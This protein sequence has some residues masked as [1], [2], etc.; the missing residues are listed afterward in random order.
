MIKSK[1]ADFKKKKS[2]RTRTRTRRKSTTFITRKN[3]K[4]IGGHLNDLCPRNDNTNNEVAI[5][6]GVV[7]Q[8]NVFVSDVMTETIDYEY[9]ITWHALKHLDTFETFPLIY[10]NS[11]NTPDNKI[12]AVRELFGFANSLVTNVLFAPETLIEQP[13]TNDTSFRIH[14]SMD[15]FKYAI[16]CQWTDYRFKPP[17]DM[18]TEQLINT[19]FNN[20]YAAEFNNF[21]PPKLKTYHVLKVISIYR[22]KTDP[23]TGF[24]APR[25]NFENNPIFSNKDKSIVWDPHA[26]NTMGLLFKEP[27][28]TQ[29]IPKTRKIIEIKKEP[30]NMDLTGDLINFNAIKI[31]SSR[32][33]TPTLPTKAEQVVLNEQN[34]TAKKEAVKLAE[35]N[36]IESLKETKRKDEETRITKEAEAVAAKKLAEETEAVAAKKLA[37]ETEAA[38]KLAEEAEAAKKTTPASWYNV[39]GYFSK[40]GGKKTRKNKKQNRK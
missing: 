4:F 19:I 16:V 13:R 27:V 21:F 7:P 6:W 23:Y 22:V 14:G 34:A 24:L 37:E 18:E 31:V 3:K 39:F 29:I 10:L 38:K 28:S 2:T 15:G 20:R 11:E 26:E 35:A 30:N 40:K 36:K 17:G 25:Y 12:N 9:V 32:P 1:R 8:G 33:N 5:A